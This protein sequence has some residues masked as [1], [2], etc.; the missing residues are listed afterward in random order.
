MNMMDRLK[1]ML[2][3]KKAKKPAP[4][5]KEEATEP[6]DS[7]AEEMLEDAKGR[8]MKLRVPFKKR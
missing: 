4:D 8:P 6:V 5:A 7:P 2:T 3:G 1:V